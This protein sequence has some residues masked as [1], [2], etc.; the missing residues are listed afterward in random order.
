MPE[1]AVISTR[2]NSW[3]EIAEY[4]GRNV[5]TVIRWEQE[6]GLPVHRVPVGHRRA[7]FAYRHE[8]DHWLQNGFTMADGA[9]AAAPLDPPRNDPEFKPRSVT[10]AGASS[11]VVDRPSGASDARLRSA[12]QYWRIAAV[13][14]LL[15]LVTVMAVRWLMP[16]RFLFAGQTQ[17]TYDSTPKTGLVTDGSSLYF[18]EWHEGR[19][20]LSTVSVVG[21]LVHQIATPFVQAEPVGVSAN[22]RQLLVLGGDGQEQERALWIVPVDG[23]SPQRVGTLLCHSAAWSP[24]GKEIAFA[25]DNSIY[26]T[27]DNGASR[28]LLHTFTS[29]PED[30]RWSLDGKRLLFLLRNMNTWEST[31]WKL[32]L[33]ETNPFAV[34][35]LTSESS[36]PSSYNTISPVLDPQ[37]D[38]LVGT[39]GPNSTTFALEGHWLPWVSG[40]SL[41]VFTRT[42]AGV[43]DF[44]VDRRA[45]NL[46]LLRATPDRNELDWYDKKSDE[47]RPFLPGISA[48]DVDFSRDGR[49]ITYVQT[50]G[51]TLWVAHS[52]G[53]SPHQIST[54]GMTNIELPRWSPD[55]KWI[56]FT[57]KRP[58]DPYRIFISPASGGPLREASHGTDNQGAPT[59]SPDGGHLVYGRV[60]CQE[61]KTCAIEEIDLQS[62]RETT[63]PGSQGLSTARWSPD[64][65]YIVALRPDKLQV[66]LLNR[67]TGKWRK[68]ADGVNGNDLGWAPDSSAVYASKPDGDRPE[69]IRIS[70]NDHKAEPA[71]DL[72][73]F[74]KLAGR[75]D[76]WFAVTPDDSIL[77]LHIVS[78]HDVYA[79]HYSVQ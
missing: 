30:L 13:L 45:Q 1:S 17:I 14:G 2:L 75:I 69:V 12:K 3:K 71:V 39:D 40:S 37:D 21:G 51:N 10:P 24:D 61:E 7:V 11:L 57:G 35:S 22:G 76:T 56:A 46:Y 19:I 47:F 34:A 26:L 65:R 9:A 28:H 63:L 53:T 52:D 62:G 33:G 58:R 25:S 31:L 72:T 79:L 44:A 8:I 70:L 29:V 66:F 5:R 23:G 49:W 41:A 74:S 15:A 59:W 68:L 32:S 16:P 4:V 55:E 67:S 77:F 20:V 43:S 6:G 27:A 64:G 36:T 18:G 78:G 73:N 50:P 60:R 42:E 38:A 48:R 54:T